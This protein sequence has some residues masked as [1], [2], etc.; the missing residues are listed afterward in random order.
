MPNIKTQITKH[1]KTLLQDDS[2]ENKTKT[3]NCT[4]FACPLKD[5]ELSCRTECVV[6]E[7]TVTTED[8]IRT[9]TGLTEKEF[10]TRYYQ[11]RHDFNSKRDSTELSKYVWE[12]KDKKEKFEISWK[13]LKRVPKLKNGQKMC[14]LCTTEA[15]VIMKNGKNQLN[16][17]TEILNKSRHQNKFLLKNYKD[18]KKT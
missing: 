7:A 11:H 17:R 15:L 6:Y 12:L 3:C 5:S 8:N 9:Y 16:K 2:Q 1:N 14:R 18:K 10:K 4:K 13:I